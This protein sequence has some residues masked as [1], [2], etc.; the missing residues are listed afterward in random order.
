MHV[1]NA[2]SC[3]APERSEPREVR[4]AMAMYTV[5]PVEMKRRYKYRMFH[6]Q[7]SLR[8]HNECFR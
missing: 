7:L 8:T 1:G 6:M 5:R 3:A 4:A 2:T